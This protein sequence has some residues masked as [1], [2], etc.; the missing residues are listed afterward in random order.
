MLRVL[1][2]YQKGYRI[3]LDC[4]AKIIARLAAGVDV[5]QMLRKPDVLDERHEGDRRLNEFQFGLMICG[6]LRE[7]DP[8]IDPSHIAHLPAE[9]ALYQAPPETEGG[10]TNNTDA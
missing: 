4:L 2:Y 5:S 9:D 7:V 3:P 6:L 8:N 10:P 1:K